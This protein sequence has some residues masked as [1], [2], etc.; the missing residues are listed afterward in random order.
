MSANG[1]SGGGSN[2]SIALP[3]E[4]DISQDASSGSCMWYAGED[5][6]EPRSCL[7]CLAANMTDDQV[8]IPTSSFITASFYPDLVLDSAR[9]VP[10][11]S[12]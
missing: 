3:G 12:A 9:S 11:A 6:V 1:S 4:V 7:D 8:S 2:D 5:C 10:S